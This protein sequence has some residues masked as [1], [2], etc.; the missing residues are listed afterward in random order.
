MKVKHIEI[1][2]NK[3]TELT[4][5]ESYPLWNMTPRVWCRSPGGPDRSALCSQACNFLCFSSQL[6][7]VSVRIL[8]TIAS[9]ADAVKPFYIGLSHFNSSIEFA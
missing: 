7:F 9:S 1:R 8:F 5:E 3:E 6:V 2:E 4:S